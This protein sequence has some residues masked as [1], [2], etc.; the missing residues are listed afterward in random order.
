MDL[1]FYERLAKAIAAQFGSSCEV[2]VHDLKSG[3]PE[4]TIAAIENG[5]VTH[6]KKGDGPSRVVLREY[7]GIPFGFQ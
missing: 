2:V 7:H 5:H 1:T 4:H 3:D 6:R